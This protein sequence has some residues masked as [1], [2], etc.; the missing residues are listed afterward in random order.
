MTYCFSLQT[1]AVVAQNNSGISICFFA[2]VFYFLLNPQICRT[3]V[4]LKVHVF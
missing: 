3:P 1:M 2:Q 4:L